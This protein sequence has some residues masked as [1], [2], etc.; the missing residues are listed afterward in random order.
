MAYLV[1]EQKLADPQA[2][3][4]AFSAADGARQEAGG[5]PALLL[6]DPED[7]GAVL[8]VVKFASAEQALA[9]RNRPGMAEQFAKLGVDPESVRVRVFDELREPAGS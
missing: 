5:G 7:P 9:W 6:A 4:L 3:M 8:A 2:W 1:V